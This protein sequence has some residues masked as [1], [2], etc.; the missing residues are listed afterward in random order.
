MA[1]LVC[2]DV[3]SEQRGID[4]PD[5]ESNGKNNHHVSLAA[6]HANQQKEIKV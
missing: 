2:D 5:E 3:I 1:F 6:Y 4:K